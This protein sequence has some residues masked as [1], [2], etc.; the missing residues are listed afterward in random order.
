[1]GRVRGGE[2]EDLFV[3]LVLFEKGGGHLLGQLLGCKQVGE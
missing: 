3:E 2:A 1:V